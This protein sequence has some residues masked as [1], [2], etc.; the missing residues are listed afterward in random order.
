[1]PSKPTTPSVIHNKCMQNTET[2]HIMPTSHQIIK[3]LF[4][5]QESDEHFIQLLPMNTMTARNYQHMNAT[6]PSFNWLPSVVATQEQPGAGVTF[7][8]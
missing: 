8:F 4:M 2:Q 1:M 5:E 3:H 7:H 6:M